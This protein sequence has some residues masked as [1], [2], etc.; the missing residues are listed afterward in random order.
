MTLADEISAARPER[1]KE[2]LERLYD[3]CPHA[4][5][6]GNSYA[7]FAAMLDCGAYLSAAE[8]LVPCGLHWSVRWHVANQHGA[9][10]INDTWKSNPIVNVV[11]T[12]PALALASAIAAAGEG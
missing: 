11:A 5:K 9:A 4:W 3:A 1:Q 7:R 2:M 6:G 8:S 12:T 10:T